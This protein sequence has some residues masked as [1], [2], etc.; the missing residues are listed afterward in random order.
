[1]SYI[2][3]RKTLCELHGGVY[4]AGTRNI[5]IEYLLSYSTQRYGIILCVVI[6]YICVPN[7]AAGRLD[8]PRI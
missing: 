7:V 2:R 4:K 5:H 3:D 1:M 8:I 6:P